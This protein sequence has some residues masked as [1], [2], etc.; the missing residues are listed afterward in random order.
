M[1]LEYWLERERGGLSKP[2]A[3]CVCVS[4]SRAKG[5]SLGDLEGELGVGER[6]EDVLFG[7]GPL[8][9]AVARDVGDANEVGAGRHAL[10]EA[11]SSRERFAV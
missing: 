7:L 11:E 8:H 10:R 1:P 4:C 2:L 3:V 9:L 5:F 6:G